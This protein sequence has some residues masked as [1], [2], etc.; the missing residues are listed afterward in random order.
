MKRLMLLV[1][2]LQSGLAMAQGLS[3]FYYGA[4]VGVGESNFN[5]TGLAETSGK[6][7]LM[8]GFSGS[9]HFNDYFALSAE[10]L[11]NSKSANNRDKVTEPGQGGI[12][13]GSG[14]DYFYTDRYRTLD[15]E[16][17]LLPK[18]TIGKNGFYLQ[19]FAGPSLNFNIGGIEARTFEDEN[20]NNQNGYAE[21]PM[22]GLNTT[23]FS[24]VYGLGVLVLAPNEQLFSVDFR[25][26]NGLSPF[27]SFNNQEARYSF[28]AVSLGYVL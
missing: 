22:T 10:F 1:C 21:R 8:G 17:P 24:A 9:Y 14:T 3:G 20:Y 18:F 2:M 28:F 4:K 16:I 11:L 23:H 6:L 13:G 15:I 12:F 27:K 26:S 25:M 7:L 19:A 5:S